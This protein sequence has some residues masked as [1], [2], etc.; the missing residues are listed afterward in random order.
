MP[1]GPLNDKTFIHYCLPNASTFDKVLSRVN[2]HMGGLIDEGR[3]NRT[4][5]LKR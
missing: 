3:R 5:W 4:S 1:E 2:R